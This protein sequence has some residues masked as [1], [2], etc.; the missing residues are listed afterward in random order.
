MDNDFPKR[1]R[2]RLQNFDYNTPRAYF[3]TIC[4]KDRKCSLSRVVGGDVL[5]A[6]KNVE[7]LPFGKIADKFINQLRD[8]YDI[9]NIDRYVIMPNHIH[10]ILRVFEDG[11]SRTS[12]PTKKQHTIVS[13]FVSTFKRFSNKECG[14]NVW[15][16]GFHDHVIR[17]KN[18]YDTI[19]KYIYEN[20]LKWQDDCFYTEN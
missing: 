10:I 6:P 16:R 7:L 17:D 18:D 1:K 8:F 19:N 9:I 2:L 20:P 5:D 12:P 15:Q 14:D 13:R 4:T 11:A 3:I